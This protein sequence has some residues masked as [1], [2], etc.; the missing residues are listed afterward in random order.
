LQTLDFSLIFLWGF[1]FFLSPCTE[2]LEK[3]PIYFGG[4]QV[5]WLPSPRVRLSLEDDFGYCWPFWFFMSMNCQTGSLLSENKAHVSPWW[6]QIPVTRGWKKLS[7]PSSAVPPLVL[8]FLDAIS[9]QPS[10]TVSPYMAL[11][12]LQVQHLRGVTWHA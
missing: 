9:P 7:V 8:L 6:L 2:R 12:W 4:F 1:F 3:H 5:L 10:H 11:N